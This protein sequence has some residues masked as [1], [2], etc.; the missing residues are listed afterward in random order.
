M[1]GK[2]VEQGEQEANVV[3]GEGDLVLMLVESSQ[4]EHEGELKEMTATQTSLRDGTS[5]TP[6]PEGFENPPNIPHRDA[7]NGIDIKKGIESQ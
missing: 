4:E 7:T 1:R 6:V 5:I 2:I 3:E